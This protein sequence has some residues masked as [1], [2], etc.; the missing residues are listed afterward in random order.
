MTEY[1]HMCRQELYESQ[2]R[3]KAGSEERVHSPSVLDNKGILARLKNKIE[4]GDPP[5]LSQADK[6]R[7]DMWFSSLI[8]REE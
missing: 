4:P 2:K 5:D 6:R 3:W 1:C 7:L 8:D